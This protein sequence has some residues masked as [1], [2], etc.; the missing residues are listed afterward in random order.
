MMDEDYEDDLDKSEVGGKMDDLH[1]PFSFEPYMRFGLD[2]YFSFHNLHGHRQKV[3]A[4]FQK[5]L[6]RQDMK[7]IEE[8][9]HNDGMFFEKM[10]KKEAIQFLKDS[11][12]VND[13]P[14]KYFNECIEVNNCVCPKCIT[15]RG[16]YAIRFMEKNEHPTNT[17]NK[18]IFSKLSLGVRLYGDKVGSMILCHQTVN[19][20]VF[21]SI[22]RQN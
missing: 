18:Y 19:E 7:R 10:K 16:H 13:S 14:F 22:S 15:F 3:I 2:H 11:F 17:F 21:E 5:A 8:F 9:L 12:F 20:H 1:N 4:I 6:E